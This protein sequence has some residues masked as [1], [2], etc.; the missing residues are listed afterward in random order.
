MKYRLLNVDIDQYYL[1]EWVD[2]KKELSDRNKLKKLIS[3]LIKKHTDVFVVNVNLQ[4]I[5]KI[6]R[7]IFDEMMYLHEYCL[8]RYGVLIS[9]T[10]MPRN[11]WVYWCDLRGRDVNLLPSIEEK[12][13]KIRK[14]GYGF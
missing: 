1:A 4:G 10:G 14:H 5:E 13:S 7:G 6:S 2:G 3:D 9:F 8:R 12:Y 11:Y